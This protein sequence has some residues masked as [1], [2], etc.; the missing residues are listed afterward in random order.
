MVT[1]DSVNATLGV[2]LNSIVPT[3]ST[4]LDANRSARPDKLGLA[5]MFTVTEL[6][7]VIALFTDTV[8]TVI[9]SGLKCRNPWN[10]LDS[11]F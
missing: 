4:V 1:F 5:R 11:L 9:V 8:V 2:L 3:F 10:I 6:V 7:P